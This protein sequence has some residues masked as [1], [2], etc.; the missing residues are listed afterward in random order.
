MK[1]FLALI[2]CVVYVL[3]VLTVS[4]E[5]KKTPAPKGY[6]PT[7]AVVVKVNR[8]TDTVTVKDAVGRM[9][10]FYGCEDWQVGDVASL[11]MYDRGTKRVKDDK[12][13]MAHYSGFEKGDFN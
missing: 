8:K 9:W 12:I 3:A 1:K 7:T 5:A 11:L 2:L 4:V 10:E 6:Y 13:V